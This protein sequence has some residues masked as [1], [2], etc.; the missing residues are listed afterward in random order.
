MKPTSH[1]PQRCL[2]TVPSL[3]FCSIWSEKKASKIWQTSLVVVALVGPLLSFS[4]FVG[5]RMA[6]LRAALLSE[7]KCAFRRRVHPVL[8]DTSDEMWSNGS[9]RPPA[10]KTHSQ[11]QAMQRKTQANRT[12]T[13]D[14]EFPL[15][16][17]DQRFHPDPGPQCRDS[18]GVCGTLRP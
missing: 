12:V 7:R 18:W 1:T 11:H 14:A 4:I 15:D 6:C 16:S 10:F 5:W 17:G 8:A 3:S 13:N 2:L 9:A